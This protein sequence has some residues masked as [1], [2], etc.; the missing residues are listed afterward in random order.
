MTRVIDR[1]PHLT[2]GFVLLS[3]LGLTACSGSILTAPP[4]EQ[5]NPDLRP[6]STIINRTEVSKP[7]SNKPIPDTETAQLMDILANQSGEKAQEAVDTI[8]NANDS[9]FISVF[10]ELLRG[11]QLAIVPGTRQDLFI[12]ALESLSGQSFGINWHAWVEWYGKTDNGTPPGFI[13][14]K[15]DLLARIDPEFKSFLNDETPSRIRVEEIVWGGVLVDGIPALDNPIMI[16]A[17]QADYLADEPV[18]GI[19]IN[20]DAR[21][22]P[23]RIMDWH[24][25]ANDVVGGVPV[26][27]AYCT[28]CG[29]G[30]AFKGELPNGENLTFGSSGL[31]YRSNKLM[32]DRHTL[33]LWNQLT[34]EPVL[35]EL[36][37]TN[38]KLNLLPI[39]LTT[40]KDWQK[41]HPDTK[42]LS[43]ETG[44]VRPYEP[45]S[46]YGE[47]FASADTMFPVWLRSDQLEDKERVYAL[48][49]N[50]VPKAYPLNILLAE[51]VVNDTLNDIPIVLI[52]VRDSVEVEGKQYLGK[53][54]NYDSGAEVR[55]F[56]RGDEIFSPGPNPET[57]IDSSGRIWDITE[58]ALIGPQ[59]ERAPRVNGHL[60]YWFGW[61]SFFPKTLVYTD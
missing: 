16:P 30:I 13:N 17:E 41:Q 53:E 52:A 15:G 40:W 27:L 43:P 45:G 34:G 47:Y 6:E 36:V 32:Y 12:N 56:N 48:N 3:V 46:A 1:I 26:S 31:L 29:A 61:F 50:G 35:G 57:L 4:N 18:F 55:A 10:I 25:M 7:L 54:I 60:A 28:L 23:L 8:L 37:D 19:Y 59:R 42:V 22:Y 33:T 21:A 9:R 5:I 44:Y 38:L 11:H 20:N 24:E 14:W 2:L 49:I 51:K 39:V 58:E